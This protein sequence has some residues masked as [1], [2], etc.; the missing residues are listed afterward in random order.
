[1][2]RTRIVGG[3][4]VQFI[5]CNC[6]ALKQIPMQ[7]EGDK[8]APFLRPPLFSFSIFCWFSVAIKIAI[9]K[10]KRKNEESFD[11]AEKRLPFWR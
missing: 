2:V 11:S 7:G 9:K 10:G 4:Q 8:T 1:M 5:L 3:S 6:S